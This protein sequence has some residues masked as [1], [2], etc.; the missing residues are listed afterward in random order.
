MSRR[1]GDKILDNKYNTGQV[2]HEFF[3]ARDMRISDDYV[4]QNLDEYY[5]SEKYARFKNL[6]DT[7]ETITSVSSFR[8]DEHPKRKLPKARLNDYF[9]FVIEE[10]R[11]V[12]KTYSMMEFV[13]GTCEYLGCNYEN[14]FK[15]MNVSHKEQL[16]NELDKDYDVFSRM[17]IKKL[18]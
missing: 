10:V 7:I 14:M 15:E 4:D 16:L 3:H 6:L 12:D 18:F 2:E 8:L 5:N 11:K 1:H 17:N 9:C 13:I